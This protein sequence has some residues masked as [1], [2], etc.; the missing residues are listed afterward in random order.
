MKLLRLFVAVPHGL[1]RGA[2]CLARMHPGNVVV[3]VY[4]SNCF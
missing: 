1:A 4:F 3:R 2:L